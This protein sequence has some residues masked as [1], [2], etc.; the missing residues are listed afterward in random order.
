MYQLANNHL[1]AQFDDQA[2][3]VRL[4]N[5]QG[6]CGNVIDRPAD[7][8]FRLVGKIGAN[9]ENV[10]FGRQQSFQISVQGD[11]LTAVVR[12]PSCLNRVCEL[13]IT[14][15]VRLQDDQLCF[16]SVLDHAEPDLLITDWT[17]PILGQI[18][19]LA[20]GQPD[21]LWPNHLGERYTQINKWPG[22][23]A[24]TYPGGHGRGASMQWLALVESDQT[25][26]LSGR[27]QAVYSSEMRVR[28]APDTE[29]RAGVIL[30]MTKLPFARSG[31]TW[32][33]PSYLLC[34]YTG[35]W[36]RSADAY[37]AW[38]ATWRRT[39]TPPEWI[40]NLSGYFLVIN[41]QQYG[42]ELWPYATLPELYAYAQANGCDTVGLFGW[43]DGGHDNTYPELGTSPTLGGDDGLKAGISQVQAQGGHVTLYF[44]GHLLDLSTE[45][46]RQ[47][48]HRIESKSRWGTPYFESYN[49]SHNSRFLEV[50]TSKFFSNA[51]P[52]C[53]EWQEEMVRRAE[54]L[55]EFAPDGVLYDQIGGMHPYPC[56]DESHP[57]PENRPSLACVPGRV[58]VL[59]GIQQRTKQ[60]NPEMAFFTEHI[61]DIYSGYADILHGMYVNPDA[62]EQR[63]RSFTASEPSLLLNFPELFRYTFPDTL[64]TI[65]NGRP[66]ISRRYLHY[67][68]VFGLRLEMELRYLDDQIA[69]RTDRHP[70]DRNRAARLSAFRRR[71]WH[72]LGL[73]R[74][75]DDAPIQNE[76][77]AI[78]AK[79]FVADAEL[80]VALWN[81]TDRSQVVRLVIAGFTL[82]EVIIPDLDATHD[83][84]DKV[85]RE[86]PAQLE[87]QSIALLI[88]IPDQS[89]SQEE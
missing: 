38:A 21:L 64:V 11:T 25:L 56:F 45:Y 8:I 30:E 39:P 71:Y 58:K 20:G 16:D 10:I 60:L 82:R 2:R 77:P 32:R 29:E 13:T 9:W 67:A 47:I 61:T 6:G 18:R 26:C 53:P 74:F 80:G 51:C 23:L 46:Y 54:D 33:C 15:T 72:L 24:L 7:E 81:D 1:L 34:L 17:Y 84:A 59:A 37:R 68:F 36:H 50:Y 4:V 22:D 48:G 27:D 78:L 3:L 62:R 89:S 12:R 57:H 44:Q 63:S 42:E 70:L 40:R 49:K 66:F 83:E 5:R 41:K 31:E 19:S 35:S 87:P 43:Y 76:N 14:L 65:R 75:C 69:I 86:L 88:Y 79:T 52:S 28:H 85:C 55:A 73:G